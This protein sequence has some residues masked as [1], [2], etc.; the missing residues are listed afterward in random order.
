LLAVSLLAA[1]LTAQHFPTDAEIQAL[2]EARVDAGGAVGIAIG[3]IDADGTVRTFQAGSAGEGAG[4][5]DSSTLFE[6][7]S[8]SKVFTGTLLADMA[9][10]GDV[11][12][13]DP[14]QDYLPDGVTMPSRGGVQIA[15]Q[16]LSTHRSGLPRLPQNLR[17]ADPSN[18][19]ADYTPEMMYEFLSG[20]ELP[21]DVDAQFEYSNL[22]TGLLGFV[23]ANHAGGDYETLLK[24]RIL[25]PLSM[26]ESGIA[27]TPEME[28]AMAKGHD[29][30][31]AI[32]PLWDLPSLAGAGA[33]RSNVDD[34]VRFLA[35]NLGDPSTDLERSMRVAHEP[36][37]D[38]TGGQRIGLNWMNRTDDEVRVVW[39]NGGTAGFRTFAGFDPDAGVG[40][41]VLTN[42]GIG[43]DDIGFHLLNPEVPLAPPALPGFARRESV[44]VES[45][46][47]ER[48]VGD[49]Q[50]AP[51]LVASF[52]VEE[53]QLFTELTGQPRIELFA[54]SETVFFLR[55][56]EAEFEFEVDESGIGSAVTLR[57]NGQTIRAQRVR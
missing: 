16:H 1:P 49:Y 50:L 14:V 39:H 43:A 29:A 24:A 15:L 3:L 12:L 44:E 23:L 18:P 4:T 30:S 47:L 52:T 7:G 28:S 34:M 13:D 46:V 48:Y 45:R 22:G 41:V 9:R 51:G 19:Y 25:G 35:A 20:Y 36:R 8:I 26:D 2:L 54:A 56:V 42:S 10:T 40:A 33:I 38:A 11:S 55:V 27:L 53:G 21:R 17:P 32:V 57:Q 31:G 6:I 37:A 5:L